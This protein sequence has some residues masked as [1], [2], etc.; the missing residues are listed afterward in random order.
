MAAFSLVLAGASQRP[1]Y[2]VNWPALE[3]ALSKYLSTPSSETAEKVAVLLPA[4]SDVDRSRQAFDV[5]SSHRIF[6]HLP[7]L[8]PLILEGRTDAI[9]VSFA[10]T[11]I[12]DGHFS[13]TLLDMLA[14]SIEMNAGGFLRVLRAN[15]GRT[16]AL[17]ELAED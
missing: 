13:E 12:S 14:S 5:E 4:G 17:C 11:E 9:A 15:R 6:D 16:F 10:L 3:A 1:T 2:R 8:E 7:R